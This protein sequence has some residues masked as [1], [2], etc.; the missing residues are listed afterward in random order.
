MLWATLR[1]GATDFYVAA[2]G[3]PAGPGTLARPYD[4]ESALSG[5]VGRA[6]DTFWL[7]GGTYSL[8]HVDTQIHGEA[9]RPITFRARPGEKPRVDGSFTIWN[10]IG[11]VIFRDFELFNSSP[12][13]VS[14]QILL[15]FNPT[16]IEITSGIS[17]HSP[18]CRFI[19][20]VIHDQTRHGIYIS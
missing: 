17:S 9:G 20:L 14:A 7:R 10:S 12:R 4:L 1:V 15:G 19:N 8:G 11:H 18:N 3:T 13:R 5:S 2:D 6:G 16:D